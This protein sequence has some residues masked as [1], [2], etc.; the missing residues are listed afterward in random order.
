[1]SF[2]R[3]E[4][5]NAVLYRADARDVVAGLE[6]DA[7][8]TDPVWPNC[9]PG[10]LP[11]ADDPSG[12]LGDVLGAL[13]A[14]VRRLVVCMRTDSDPRILTA[15]PARF[16]FF[17][18]TNME[19]AATGYI[20]RK[21]GGMEVAYAFGE[22]IRSAEGQR[23]IPGN[24]PKAQPGEVAAGHPCARAISHMLF[25]CRWYSDEG[26][27]VLDPFMGS[28]T[29]GVA[30]ARLGRRFIG[31]EIEPRYFD[32]ACKR[33]EQAQKQADLFTQPEATAPVQEALL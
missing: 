29:T 28:G 21:L 32:I 20:G 30:C 31:I 4:I 12:L 27:A 1:M 16:P 14:E 9:P 10:F 11:G 17:R 18:T 22:P 7:V 26:E 33:I 23:V 13:K 8:I 19:Y 24:A 5:G 2:E 3:V 25:L 6:A 15:V